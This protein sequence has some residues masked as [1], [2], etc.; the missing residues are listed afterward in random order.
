MTIVE[1]KAKILQG[2]VVGGDV[3]SDT[4]FDVG[5]ED[6]GTTQI[7]VVGVSGNIDIHVPR[8]E[9]EAL[10]FDEKITEGIPFAGGVDPRRITSGAG[11]ESH[12]KTKKRELSYH[13]SLLRRMNKDIYYLFPVAPIRVPIFRCCCVVLLG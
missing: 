11:R 12:C 3:G 10:P 6:G 4:I 9:I 2:D 7:E 8:H 1:D 5:G 13:P